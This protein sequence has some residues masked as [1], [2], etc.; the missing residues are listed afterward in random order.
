M[1]SVAKISTRGQ[2]AIP[3][4]IRRKL[5]IKEGD[6]IIFEERDEG[7][8]IRRVK[9]FLDMQGS[10]PS[11]KLTIEKIKDKAMEEMAK[12]AIDV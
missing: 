6:T 10:L 4:E 12:E 9:N 2:V 11:L 5:S 3:K 1:V 8:Y 7:I